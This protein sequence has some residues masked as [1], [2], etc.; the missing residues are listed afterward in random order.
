MIVVL[1][2]VLVVGIM[3]H[4]YVFRPVI[5]QLF[6]KNEGYVEK[7]VISLHFLVEFMFLVV[8]YDLFFRYLSFYIG[9]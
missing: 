3:M 4:H 8:M 9:V 7:N 2:I 6:N 1:I 5:N